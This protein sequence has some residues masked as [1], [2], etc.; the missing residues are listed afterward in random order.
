MSKVDLQS[1][2]R[3]VEQRRSKV[4]RWT[5]EHGSLVRL[6]DDDKTTRVDVLCEIC[7]LSQRDIRERMNAA[8][9]RRAVDKRG[10]KAIVSDG[11]YAKFELVESAIRR[12]EVTVRGAYAMSLEA[13]LSGQDPDDAIPFTGKNRE[14]LLRQSTLMAMVYSIIGRHEEWFDAPEEREG[15]LGNSP[16]GPSSSSAAPPA[17]TASPAT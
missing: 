2:I 14:I 10:L 5:V 4:F 3:D 16:D 6:D 1:L 11:E 17:E 7:Y 15:E 12:L 13:D 9:E 8:L